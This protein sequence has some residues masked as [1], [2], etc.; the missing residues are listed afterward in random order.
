[1][2]SPTHRA[3]IL[4]PTFDRLAVGATTDSSGRIIF[5]QIFCAARHR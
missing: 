1:M 4:E 3:N 5:A 2:N